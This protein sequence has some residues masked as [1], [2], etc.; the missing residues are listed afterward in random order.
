MMLFLLSADF[1]FFIISVHNS[2]ASSPSSDTEASDSLPTLVPS[3]P[4]DVSLCTP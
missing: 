2:S 3:S 1:G 4:L